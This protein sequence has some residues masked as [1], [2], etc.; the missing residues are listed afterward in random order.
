MAKKTTVIGFEY[1]SCTVVLRAGDW[2]YPEFW[3]VDWLMLL[4]A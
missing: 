1:L 2:S 3:T 4:D